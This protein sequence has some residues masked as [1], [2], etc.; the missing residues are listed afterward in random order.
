MHSMFKKIVPIFGIIFM[1]VT[2]SGCTSKDDLGKKNA[3]EQISFTSCG[4]ESSFLKYQGYQSKEACS[5][6]RKQVFQEMKLKCS[7]KFLS[8]E[9][10]EKSAIWFYNKCLSNSLDAANLEIA[11]EYAIFLQKNSK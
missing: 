7:E 10:E 6:V 2:L 9:L 8:P 11:Q 5:G 4:H 3:E 1:A